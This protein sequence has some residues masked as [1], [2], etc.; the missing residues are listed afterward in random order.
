[1]TS[2][3]AVLVI[4]AGPAGLT[5]AHL[6]CQRGIRVTVLEADPAYVGGL[7]RTVWHRGYGCDIG[8]HRFFTT[9]ERVKALW[10]TWLP[11]AFL[12]RPRR[13]RIYFRGAFYAY[14]LALIPTLA[15]LGAL[16]SCRCVSSYVWA[17]LRPHRHIASFE[18]WVVDRFGTRL[19]RLF[20]K[21]YTEKVWGMPCTAISADWAAQRIQGLSLWRAAVSSLFPHKQRPKTLVTAFHY[22]RQGPGML[23]ERAAECVRANGGEIRMGARVTALTYDGAGWRVDYTDNSGTH[24]LHASHIISSM[25][26]RDLIPALSPAPPAQVLAAAQSLTYRDFLTVVLIVKDRGVFSDQWI[27][28]HAP[29]VQ[30]A[31]IQNFKAW[32]EAMVPD[33]AYT[34]YGMEYFCQ[35]GD[36][37]WSLSDEDLKALAT[38]ELVALNLAAIEDVCD[39]LVIRQPRA[40]PVY[41]LDYSTPLRVLREALAAYAPH[42]Q[43]VGRAGMHRYN[44]QDH[45][46]MTAMLAVEN[47]L[48]GTG[49]DV[50]RVNADAVYHE[51]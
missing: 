51:A 47:L 48:D 6:L 10:H 9:S 3:D 49:W 33:P 44:N 25:P 36:A 7:A 28:V 38:R 24:S 43:V 35:E 11:D 29:E 13:S 32:S 19:Y 41:P 46:M 30:V 16:E 45:A 26:L 37:L 22:P 20:F 31:R 14:P 42:L 18:D 21:T 1:M 40:Y 27:Y 50:W 4:G 34:S 2:P 8:G 23:W 12:T 39:A 5:A 15:Q 17:K